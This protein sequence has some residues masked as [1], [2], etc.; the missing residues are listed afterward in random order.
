MQYIIRDYESIYNIDIKWE[1]K[2]LNTVKVVLENPICV[3]PS[4][5][6]IMCYEIIDI[7]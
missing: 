2:P 5:C 6:V 4:G 3:W 1:R 7:Q